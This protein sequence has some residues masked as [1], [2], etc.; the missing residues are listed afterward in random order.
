M[1]NQR[2][3][4]EFGTGVR[5]WAYCP[6]SSGRPPDRP[7]GPP[8]VMNPA[9]R[10]TLPGFAVYDWPPLAGDSSPPVAAP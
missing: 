2:N 5:W 7:L 10:L 6:L 1:A 9:E 4:G 8:E 3:S